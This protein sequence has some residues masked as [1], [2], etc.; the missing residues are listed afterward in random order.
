MAKVVQLLEG[1][2]IKLSG[3][4]E[5]LKVSCAEAK[6]NFPQRHDWTAFF[7]DAT[8]LNELK[9]GER[10]DTVILRNL[11]CKWFAKA[12]G[13]PSATEGGTENKGKEKKTKEQD[14]TMPSA[15]K[16][17]EVFETFGKLRAMDVPLLDPA[18]NTVK[19]NGLVHDL[20]TLSHE[21]VFEAYVQ[22]TEY[23]GFVKC[24][25]SL[26]GLKLLRKEGEDK[27]LTVNFKV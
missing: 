19:P 22:F 8:N 11:P 27:S 9:P 2:T 5:G 18:R 3:F 16:V 7:R 21:L 6:L 25:T 1:C 20:L 23:A 15:T 14:N 24:M 10:P 12:N 17:K 26:Y 4:S 13:E